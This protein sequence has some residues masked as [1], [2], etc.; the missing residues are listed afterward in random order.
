MAEPQLRGSSLRALLLLRHVCHRSPCDG[1][2][3]RCALTWTGINAALTSGPPPHRAPNCPLLP[4]HATP[5][6]SRSRVRR[7]V[8]EGPLAQWATPPPVP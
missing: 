1:H 6:G 5:S 4:Q 3:P 2:A 7:P 8:N